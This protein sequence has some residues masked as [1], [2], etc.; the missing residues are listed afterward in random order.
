MQR[1]RNEENSISFKY[2]EQIVHKYDEFFENV[3]QKLY[4]Y[5][6]KNNVVWLDSEDSIANNTRI[7]ISKIIEKLNA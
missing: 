2:V 3:S 4:G 1:G 5:Y 6:N 7:V